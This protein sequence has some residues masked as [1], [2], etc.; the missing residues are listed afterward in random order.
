[1]TR[2]DEISELQRMFCFMEQR[3]S[4]YGESARWRV[5]DNDRTEPYLKLVGE[6]ADDIERL[7]ELHNA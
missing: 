7:L 2:K 5:G 4:R 6:I 1:M 3:R